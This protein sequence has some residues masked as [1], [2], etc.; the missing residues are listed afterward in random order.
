MPSTFLGSWETSFLPSWHFPPKGENEPQ[1]PKHLNKIISGADKAYEGN[2]VGRS[3]GLPGGGSICTESQMM[4]SRPCKGRGRR[5]VQCFVSCLH[6]QRLETDL[7]SDA[8][9]DSVPPSPALSSPISATHCPK[10]ST[11]KFGS[12]TVARI[13]SFPGTFKNNIWSD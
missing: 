11:L 3:G 5:T 4:R 13:H 1:T 8:G 7:D 6:C 9:S 12:P 10:Y 2:S